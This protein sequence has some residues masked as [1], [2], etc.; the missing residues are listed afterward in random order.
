MSV[1]IL[2]GHMRYLP[3]IVGSIFVSLIG[4]QSGNAQQSF[5]PGTFSVDGIPVNCGPVVFVLVPDL[6]DV[7]RSD[8]QGHIFLNPNVLSQLPT[9]LKLYWVAHE[10][11]HYNVGANELAADCWAI[12]HG[13]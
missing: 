3:L 13:T 1:Y 4:L 10:C 6:N 7:G 12:R 11:G 8:L 2:G 9:P 5:P